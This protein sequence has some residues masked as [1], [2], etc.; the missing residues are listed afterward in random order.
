MEVPGANGH[1][2]DGL[3]APTSDKA[4]LK[5]FSADNSAT[6]LSLTKI[7]V[8]QAAD[9]T[10]LGAVASVYPTAVS[11]LQPSERVLV[12]DEVTSCEITLLYASDDFCVSY[13]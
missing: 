13:L 6:V 12:I 8:L 9:G 10:S 5:I 7:E 3:P 4:P 11:E 2:A 1:N